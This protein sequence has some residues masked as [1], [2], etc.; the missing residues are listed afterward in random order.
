MSYDVIILSFHRLL[1]KI[2]MHIHIAEHMYNRS[3]FS[4]YIHTF[5]TIY[6]EV[7]TFQKQEACA[8]PQSPALK[9]RFVE[10]GFRAVGGKP[11][12]ARR[13]SKQA[14]FQKNGRRN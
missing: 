13:Q 11:Y 1:C 3:I 6:N 14:E 12:T 8:L 7:E 4:I 5:T 9:T 2:D 10:R